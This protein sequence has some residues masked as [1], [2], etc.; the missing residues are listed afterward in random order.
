MS[1]AKQAKTFTAP[2]TFYKKFERKDGNQET[3]HTAPGRPATSTSTSPRRTT[4]AS[5]TARS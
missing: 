1:T 4:S 5:R 2:P 3:T